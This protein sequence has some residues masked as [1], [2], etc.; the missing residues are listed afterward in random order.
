MSQHLSAWVDR[1]EDYALY[2]ESSAHVRWVERMSDGQADRRKAFGRLVDI[3]VWDADEHLELI[4]EKVPVEFPRATMD[5]AD[6]LA[7]HPLLEDGRRRDLTG[8]SVFTIDDAYTTDMDD[9]V[10]VDLR[11]DGTACVGVHITDV[12]ALVPIGSDLDR[13][14]AGR[15]SS[16]YFPD[17]KIPML[18]KRISEDLGSLRPGMPRLALSLLFD[19]AADGSVADVEIVPSLIRCREKLAYEQVDA[20]LEDASHPLY[21]AMSALYRTAEAQWIVRLQMGAVALER[22]ECQIRVTP[23]KEVQV[24]VR[25]RNSR[26]NLLVS[27]LMV[28]ANVAVAKFCMDR[29]IPIVYRTQQT[30]DLSDLEE[31]E[32]EVLRRHQTLRRMR[33]AE[34]ALE[35]GLHGGLGVA[36]YCQASSPLRRYPDLA[37][38][39]QIT[40]FLLGEAPPYDLEGIREVSYQADERIREAGRMERRRNRYWFL[41]YLQDFSGREFDAVVLEAQE[42]RLYVEVLEYGFQTDVRPSRPAEPGEAIVLRLNR[43]DAWEDTISFTQVG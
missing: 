33:P 11:E 10:S 21:G 25:E 6:A 42:R 34:L 30:P 20:A 15:V 5:A 1:L 17:R 40:A 16:L 13:E 9:G 36:F 35:P 28:M 2:G 12:A 7:L 32:N 29:D 27:E 3:G 22:P 23:E 26:A 38:Q 37:V 24:S 8:L 43:S 19:V 4:I 39:R 14:A 31:V 41:K 18:P